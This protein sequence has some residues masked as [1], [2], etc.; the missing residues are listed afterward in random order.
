MER[1]KRQDGNYGEIKER[2]FQE[3]K[4][5]FVSLEV[6]ENLGEMRIEDDFGFYR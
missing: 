5:G 6:A 4:N 2:E 3:G 1:F